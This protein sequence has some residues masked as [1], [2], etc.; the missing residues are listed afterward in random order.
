MASTAMGD[1]GGW[2]GLFGGGKS[3]QHAGPQAGQILPWRQ[4]TYDMSTDYFN[5]TSGLM[6]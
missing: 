5:Q 2:E 3:E 6:Q 1:F 4:E